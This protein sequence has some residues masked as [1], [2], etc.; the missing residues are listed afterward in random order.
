[1]TNKLINVPLYGFKVNVIECKGSSDADEVATFFKKV[2]FVG[3]ITA[4]IITSVRDGDV[5]GGWTLAAFGAKRIAVVLLPMRSESKRR[6]VLMHE[7]RHVEDDILRHC[8][9]DD[10]EAAAYLSGHLGKYFF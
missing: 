7:K 2:R 9:V 10:D 4:E 3:D 6:E 8:G 5:D 1:M